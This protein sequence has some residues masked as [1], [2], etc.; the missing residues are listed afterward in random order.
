MFLTGIAVLIYV[1]AATLLSPRRSRLAL[2]EALLLGGCDG[3]RR[4]VPSR[5]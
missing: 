1:S 2:G 4:L 3:P 5:D